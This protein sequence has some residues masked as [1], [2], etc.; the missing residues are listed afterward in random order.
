MNRAT[1]EFFTTATH[2]IKHSKLG[3]LALLS[4]IGS[5]GFRDHNRWDNAQCAAVLETYAVGFFVQR[6]K[7][8]SDFQCFVGIVTGAINSTVFGNLRSRM[9][10]VGHEGYRDTEELL[11]FA[12]EDLGTHLLRYPNGEQVDEVFADQVRRCVIEL[13]R[14][15]K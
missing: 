6:P 14:L 13:I 7:W 10:P 4:Y 9:W 12:R 3:R 8:E 11:V 1:D 2:L 15:T 5:T